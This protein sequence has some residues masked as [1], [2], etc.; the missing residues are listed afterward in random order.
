MTDYDCSPHPKP[1]AIVHH[2]LRAVHNLLHPHHKYLYVPPIALM[3]AE[4]QMETVTVTASSD[5]PPISTPANEPPGVYASNTAN[6][7][8][9]LGYSYADDGAPSHPVSVPEPPGYLLAAPL[10]LTLYLINRFKR[11]T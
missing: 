1:E 10:L 7:T 8:S 9:Y 6:G 11:T 5:A 3:C 2:V 4:P